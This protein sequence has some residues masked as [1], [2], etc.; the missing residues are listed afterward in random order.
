MLGPRE[1]RELLDRYGLR[2]R[3][4][5]GQHFVT[6]PN[7]VRR[8]VKIAGVQA[9]DQVLEI[10]P[11][12][13]ALSLALLEAGAALIAVERDRGLEPILA[14]VG[15]QGVVFEDAMQAD[16]KK[17]LGA[18]PTDVVANLPY[19]IATPLLLDLLVQVPQIRSYTVMVQKEVGERLAAKPGSEAYGAVSVKVSYLAEASVPMRVSRRVFYPMPDVE[20][21]VVRLVRRARAPVSGGRERIFRV[22]EGGFAQRRKTIRRALRGAGWSADAVEAALERAKVDGQARAEVLGLESFAAL[23]RALPERP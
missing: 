1:T 18:R 20:S 10:G 14:D 3:T 23:A 6:D 8:I 15:I 13:G 9:G 19:Q 22:V 16:Y 21:V 5:I 4:S 12:L 11:G 2:P 7:T 17:L